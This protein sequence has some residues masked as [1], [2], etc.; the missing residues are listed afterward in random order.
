MRRSMGL[1]GGINYMGL[2]Q[3]KRERN[4]HAIGLQKHPQGPGPTNF[5]EHASSHQEKTN[6]Y[7]H[8]T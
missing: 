2:V 7:M 4:C 6:P 5:D 8:S 1:I 3:H